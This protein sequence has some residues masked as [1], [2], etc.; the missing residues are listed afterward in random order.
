LLFNKTHCINDIK[1]KHLFE[2]GLTRWTIQQNDSLPAYLIRATLTSGVPCFDGMHHLLGMTVIIMHIT[3]HCASTENSE[4][5]RRP[6][7]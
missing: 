2:L 5:S 6:L 7:R 4:G 3:K 1:S